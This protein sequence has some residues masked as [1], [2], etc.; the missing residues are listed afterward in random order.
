MVD[1]IKWLLVLL[2]LGFGIWGNSY[3]S[4]ESFLYR[5]IAIIGLSIVAILIAAS[6]QKGIII[7][8]LFKASRTEIRKVIWPTR[9]E[10]T[11]TTAIVFIMLLVVAL[12]LWLLDWGLGSIVDTVIRG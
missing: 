10:T 5:V 2:I 1:K 8:E 4:E 11:Q 12:I 3:F 7:W 9:Q 6:T